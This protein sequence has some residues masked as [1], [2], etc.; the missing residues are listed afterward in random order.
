M[1]KPLVVGMVAGPG[2]GKSTTA[3]GVFHHL[4]LSGVNCELVTEF[5]KDLVWE[6]REHVLGNQVYILGK[7]Y[8]RFWRLRDKVDVIVTDCPLF[9]SVYYGAHMSTP[10]QE[11]AI[12]LHASF[13]NMT[14]FLERVKPY[15]PKGRVQTEEKARTIDRELVVL[16]KRYGLDYRVVR[17]DANAAQT[18][19]DHVLIKLKE[20]DEIGCPHGREK[21]TMCPHCLGINRV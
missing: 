21:W 11:L 7:Q 3:A 10:F 5:A 20:P 13:D 6:G 15:N 9:L 19:A 17:A 12:E 1:K 4:K 8:H 18:I 14:F 2:T 16:L